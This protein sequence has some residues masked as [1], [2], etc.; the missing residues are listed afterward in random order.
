MVQ[1]EKGLTEKIGACQA[2]WLALSRPAVSHL[3]RAGVAR[4]GWLCMVPDSG[5]YS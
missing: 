5:R 4:K 2:A 3:D 1:K